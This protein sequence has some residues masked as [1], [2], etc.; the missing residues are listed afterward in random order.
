V[1]ITGAS[2]GI[3]RAT[4]LR[5]AARGWTVHAGVRS[6]ADGEGL[7]AEGG[8][9]IVPVQLDITSAEDIAELAARLGP[10]LDALV[11]NAGIVVQGP[12]ETLSSDQVRLQFEVNVVAQ[13]AVTQSVLPLVRAGRG[14]VVFVSS[15]SGRV[16]TPLSGA[17][18][19]SK[20]AIEALADALRVELRPW[21][22]P[23]VL[24]QPSSTATDM[25]GT[26]LE[27]HEA[28]ITGLS[29]AHAQLYAQRLAKSA[30]AVAMIQKR[31]VPVERVA[32]TI[33]TAL[34]ARRPR[35]R[36]QVDA[37]GRAQLIGTAITPTRVVD[38]VLARATGFSR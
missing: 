7:A 11:N 1:L 13:L 35:A 20:F 27:Q 15:I 26:A 25:W 10:T 30:K 24:V 23:V 2:R 9:N 19:A 8:A 33:E 3:G 37:V 21:R 32:R 5:L 29:P 4:A 18:N 12:V 14:R 34:T 6:A 17:Y 22:V 38:A 28:V 16:S 36:Y 31:A